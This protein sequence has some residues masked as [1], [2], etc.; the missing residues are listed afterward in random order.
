[1]KYLSIIIPTYNEELNIKEL[2][3]R[4]HSSMTKNKVKYE[5][6]IIDDFSEDRTL[7][8]VRQLNG[9][10]PIKIFLK[11]GAKGKAQSLLEGFSKAKYSSVAMIDADL[12][13]PPELLYEML[14]GIEQYDIMVA[15]RVVQNIKWYRKLLSRIYAKVFGKILLDLP[16]DI[17]SGMKVFKKKILKD[18]DLNPTPW[19]FDYEFLYEAKNQGY[20]ISQTPI[21]FDDRKNGKSNITLWSNFELLFGI[22]KLKFKRFLK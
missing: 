13:Y 21:Q 12:Q 5:I 1:M 10:Y 15:D 20:K 7:D 16:Y 22:L 4:I 8:I 14:V 11:K 3:K 18:V 2:I 17:Q 9:R 6:V 19:G